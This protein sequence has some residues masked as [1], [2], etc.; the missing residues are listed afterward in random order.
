MDDSTEVAEE[1][2]VAA[3]EAQDLKIS[4]NN[5]TPGVRGI[6]RT[7]LGTAVKPIG[8]LLEKPGSVKPL[9]PVH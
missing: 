6:H 7:P 3:E 1:E 9:Q 8:N 5:Q 4:Q 2:V